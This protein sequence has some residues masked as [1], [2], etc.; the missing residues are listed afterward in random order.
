[1]ATVNKKNSAP[2]HPNILGQLVGQET[3]REPEAWE[4]SLLHQYADLHLDLIELINQQKAPL[5]GPAG[6]RKMLAEREPEY[7]AR[8]YFPDY[9]PGEMPGVHREWCEDFRTV[10]QKG[11]GSSVVRV[12]PRGHAKSTL[13]DFIYPNWTIVYRKKKYILIMSDSGD[14][15]IS[16]ITNIKDALENNERI[17]ED[18]N[19]LQGDI[20]QESK[21]VTS[22]GV[23]VEALGAGMKVRGRRNK[24]KRPDLIIVDDLE[25]DEN[26]ATPDQRKKLKRWYKRALRRAGAAYTD[27]FVVGTIIDDDSL[28]SELTRTPGYDIKVYRAVLAFAEREDLWDQWKNLFINL[29]NPF[30][31]EDAR[32]F[33]VSNRTE[34]LRGSKVLWEEGN[35]NFPDGYYSIM[36][37][38]VV[39]GEESFWSELQNDPKSNEAKF[40]QPVEYEDNDRPSLAKLLLVMT[41]DPSLGKNEK[42]DFS[43]IIVLGTDRESGQMYTIVADI[44]RR[45]P[46]VTIEAMFA[47]AEFYMNQGLRFRVVGI[48]DVQ[49]QAFFATETFKRAMKRRLHLPIKPFHRNMAKNIRIEAMQ[50]S[51]NNGYVKVHKQHTLLL[52]QLRGYPKGKKDG[53]DGLEMAID[54]SKRGSRTSSD[55]PGA[56][57]GKTETSEI[58]W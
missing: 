30:R 24:E 12:A 6:I 13:W 22:T 39:D 17:R 55:R 10:I 20:W 43:A 56:V 54:L 15:A 58:D 33:F 27:F 50:P 57:V 7:F 2:K 8:A 36:V 19:D 47:T 48:E 45:T 37:A 1:M 9:I 44:A 26:T 53:P 5:F 3:A 16:F 14:Q 28:L 46:D 42:S 11:G 18:F 52:E 31:E 41:V 4:I 49:F 21:I 35:P 23:I 25:N 32:A 38:R 51:I 40:F 34:M 29:D